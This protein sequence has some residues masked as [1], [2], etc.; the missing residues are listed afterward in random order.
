M[1]DFSALKNEAMNNLKNLSYCD[2][3][4]FIS[5]SQ[6]MPLEPSCFKLYR[7]E[8]GPFKGEK[9]LSDAPDA[10]WLKEY[11]N[12]LIIFL[13]KCKGLTSH[14]LITYHCEIK[15]YTKI[16]KKPKIWHNFYSGLM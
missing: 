12:F 14:S 2:M 5:F 7:F 13:G 9:F 6:S 1:N 4:K 8:T 10:N 11:P 3:R 15:M 16:V